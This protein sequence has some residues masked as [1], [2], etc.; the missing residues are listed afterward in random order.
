MEVGLAKHGNELQFRSEVGGLGQRHQEEVG[1]A[2]K[3]NEELLMLRW[4]SASKRI[5]SAG[6][7]LYADYRLIPVRT[8]RN[9]YRLGHRLGA[10]L[11]RVCDTSYLRLEYATRRR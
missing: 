4:K 3:P 10:P 7:N 8:V 9:R 6:A 2:F 11:N 1:I 5:A